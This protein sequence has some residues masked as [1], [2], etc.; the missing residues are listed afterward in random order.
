MEFITEWLIS[1][2][3]NID[4]VDYFKTGILAVSVLLIAWIANFATKKWIVALVHKITVKTKTNWDDIVAD[5]HVFTRLSHIVPALIILFSSNY[6][7]GAYESFNNIIESGSYIYLIIIFY[8]VVN[9]LLNAVLKIYKQ[10]DISKKIHIKTFMQVFKFIIIVFALIFIFSVMLGT[11]PTAIFGV[12][13]AFVA[14]LMFV[15]KDPILN[16]YTSIQLITNEQIKL[17]DWIVMPK[18][19]ADGDVIEINMSSV[20][21][22]NFDKTVSTVPTS[23]LILSDVKNW[24]YMK[25]AG[26]RRIK[27][28]IK[29]DMNSVKHCDETMITKYSQIE[30]LKDYIK[31]KRKELK[32]YNEEHVPSKLLINTDIPMNGRNMTNLGTFRRYVELYLKHN[33]NIHNDNFTFLVRQLEPSETGVPIQIYVFTTTTAWVNYE[34]IQSDIFDHIIATVPFFDLRVFQRPTGYDIKSIVNN[35]I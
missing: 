34:K 13:G 30:I 8:W 1:L 14:M 18:Y 26:G 32:E 29:I 4:Y 31:E 6:I 9:S 7:F 12:L 17:G 19:H 20:K 11:S 21:V 10:Y 27:R 33:T 5:N 24:R 16:I 15:F 22:Q 2:G 28:A 23:E 3:I 25:E 35:N